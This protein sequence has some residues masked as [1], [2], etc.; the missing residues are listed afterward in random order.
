[1]AA[2]QLEPPTSEMARTGVL[3]A[4]RPQGPIL[5]PFFLGCEGLVVFSSGNRVETYLVQAVR[6]EGDI[7]DL[8]AQ[9]GVQRLVCGF[10]G[11]AE[12]RLLRA[13]GIDVRVGSCV[14]SVATLVARFESLPSA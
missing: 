1:M 13:R 5:S 4:L 2:P 14:E 12:H 8:I 3:V 11:A 6:I 9:S 10:I 7:C